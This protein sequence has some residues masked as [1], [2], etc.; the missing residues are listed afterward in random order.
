MMSE[1]Q[2]ELKDRYLEYFS[3]RIINEIQEHNIPVELAIQ[4]IKTQPLILYQEEIIKQVQKK[5]K[6]VLSNHNH[7]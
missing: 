3:T 7:P 6:N 5:I 2:K 4:Y 1:E